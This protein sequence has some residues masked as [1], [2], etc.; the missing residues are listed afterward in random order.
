MPREYGC[1]RRRS[2]DAIGSAYPGLFIQVFAVYS[3]GME[4]RLLLG[5]LGLSLCLLM[6]GLILSRARRQGARPYL[7]LVFMEAAVFFLGELLAVLLGP[8][9][10]GLVLNWSFA[11][12]GLP[13]L[14]LHAREAAGERPARPNLHF[15]PALLLLPLG[16]GLALV[17]ASRGYRGGPAAALLLVAVPLAETLQLLFYGRAGIAAAKRAD[18]KGAAPWTRRALIAALSGYAAFLV[19]TWLSLGFLLFR[20]L[21]GEEF[22]SGSGMAL[23]P[24]LVATLLAWTLA[25]TAL[26]GVEEGLK[27]G[28]KYGGRPLPAA[29]AA[30]ILKKL[31]ALIDAALDLGAPELE[32]R[33]LARRLGL[34]Y[35]RLSQAS[36]EVEGKSLAE[37]LNEKRV[38][39]AKALLVSSKEGVLDIAL[40]AGFR[41]KS[42]FN[43]VFRKA[44]GRSPR[45][46]RR[47]ARG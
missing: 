16:S 5:V 17:T 18:A 38:E 20:E 29:E 3:R 22:L 45:E 9:A 35:Y 31:H 36:N 28:G 11:L 23:P 2:T 7:A 1:G 21:Y 4:A 14:W 27:K 34:P 37:L 41:S 26:W 43:E 13:A 25:L 19:L 32:P 10:L 47:D 40:E 15:L 12:Y 44:T 42:T 39:R 24:S 33:R 8:S 46:F 6:T 30:S